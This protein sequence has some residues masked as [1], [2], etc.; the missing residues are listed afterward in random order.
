[1]NP[2]GLRAP[3]SGIDAVFGFLS[4]G[5]RA[6]RIAVGANVAAV[7]IDRAFRVRSGRAR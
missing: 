1:L 7:V 3:E 6:Q 4:A 5:R 2:V